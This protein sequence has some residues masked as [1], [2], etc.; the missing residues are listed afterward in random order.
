MSYANWKAGK[1]RQAHFL[2][3]DIKEHKTCYFFLAPYAI[4]FTIFFIAPVI[5]SIYYGFTYFNVLQPPKFIFLR[6]YINLILADDIFL[7]A[8]KNTFLIAAITGPVGYIMAFIFA[9][10][11]HELPR[12]IRAIAVLVF[13]APTISGQV[14]LIW[15]F[16]FSGDSY[17]YANAIG[18][19]LGILES[20]KL[21]LTDPRYMMTIVIIV[22]LWASLG[23]GFLSFIAGLNTI[24]DDQYEAGYVDGVKNRW[25]ELWYITL[26]NMKS[27][28]MF[29]AV[30][31]ITT[32]FNTA[33]VT[34]A[35]CG[36]PSTDYAAR[37]VVTHLIDYGQQRFE[38][39][40]ASAIATVLFLAMYLCN[41]FIQKALMRLGT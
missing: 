35:L 26:P 22:I 37:T 8:I 34:M 38:M 11:I 18:V 32:A 29:G 4:I 6:N 25:Q 30:M 12:G 9:W 40:Y 36:F 16:I 21:W 5:V 3:K 24:P 17:G 1:K 39:G 10:L 28:L 7:T 19:D 33:D 2:W 41:K 14:Y 23:T 27:M 13:Y 20:P 15:T 31:S